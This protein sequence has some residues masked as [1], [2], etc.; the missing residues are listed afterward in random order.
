MPG[1]FESTSDRWKEEIVENVTN[2]LS[3]RNW[4]S[5]VM[6]RDEWGRNLGRPI[7]VVGCSTIRKERLFCYSECNESA[8]SRIYT[9]HRIPSEQ[10]GDTTCPIGEIMWLL[11]VKGKHANITFINCHAPTG[12][13]DQVVKDALYKQLK[14]IFHLASKNDHTRG[15]KGNKNSNK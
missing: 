12:E 3:I 9:E 4:K 2:I 7:P 8:S 10:R 1:V 5:T 6:D 11:R 13:I 15:C 14:R